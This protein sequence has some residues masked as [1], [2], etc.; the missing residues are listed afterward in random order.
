MAT[1]SFKQKKNSNYNIHI[2]LVYKWKDCRHFPPCP[3]H[4]SPRIKG[5]RVDESVRRYRLHS[6]IREDSVR[7]LAVLFQ[8]IPQPRSPAHTQNLFSLFRFH[9]R[10]STPVRWRRVTKKNPHKQTNKKTKPPG[11]PRRLLS[12]PRTCVSGGSPGTAAARWGLE[13]E[14]ARF[15]ALLRA[16]RRPGT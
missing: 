1:G 6:A 7:F 15:A 14:P 5:K 4:T 10:V 11:A 8:P 3:F 16:Q 2:T 13:R 12:V 9:R